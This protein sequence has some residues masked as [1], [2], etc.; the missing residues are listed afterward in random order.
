DAAARRRLEEFEK[1]L[2]RLLA[3]AEKELAD[4]PLE[5]ADYDFIRNFGEHL[6]RVVVAPNPARLK[7]LYEEL[8]KAKDEARRKEGE[9]MIAL[10]NGGAMKRRLVADDHTDQTA[11]QVLEEATGYVDLGVFVYRQPDGRLVLGAGP[12]LS[13]HEFKHPMRDRLTDEKWR[14]RLKGKDAP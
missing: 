5:E 6:E 14:Q 3:I 10:E 7:A 4:K 9:G 8:R 12:V 11:E 1:L 13:Y 2:E